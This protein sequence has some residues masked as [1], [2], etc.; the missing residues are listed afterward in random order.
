MKTNIKQQQGFKT[1]TAA[2]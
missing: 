1:L 2:G